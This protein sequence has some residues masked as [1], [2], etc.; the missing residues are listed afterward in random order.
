MQRR[1]QRDH[2]DLRAVDG[3]HAGAGGAERFQG[4]DRLA[5]A[6]KMACDCVR[7]ADAADEKRG[8][9]DERQELA[10]AL[11]IAFELRRGLVAGA[12][13][14]AGIGKCALCLSFDRRHRG[15]ARCRCRQTQPVLPAHQAAGLDEAAG[16]QRCFADQHARSKA[17]AAGE[18]VRFAGQRRAQLD[19]GVADGDAVAGLEIEPRSSAGSAAAPNASPCRA[20]SAGSVMS[21]AVVTV[22]N[23]G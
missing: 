11:D 5:L 20:N 4:R 13:V 19:H 8:Q 18:F 10:E 16:A 21:G 1:E 7:D 23:S 9:G 3:E 6:R 14:P 12:D 22:P 15:I 2:H 17:N